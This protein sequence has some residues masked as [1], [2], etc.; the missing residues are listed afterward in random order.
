L[1]RRGVFVI[2]GN[3]PN[4]FAVF[5]VNARLKV[6]PPPVKGVT[7]YPRV[8]ASAC[9]LIAFLIHRAISGGA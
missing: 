5:T 3:P 6:E 7:N 8:I 1:Y 2:A 9:C 4:T